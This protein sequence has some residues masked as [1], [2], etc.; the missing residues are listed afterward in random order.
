MEWAWFHRRKWWARQSAV[1]VGGNVLCQGLF[2]SVIS[3]FIAIVFSVVNFYEKLSLSAKSEASRRLPVA[4]RK[5]PISA[6]IDHH[7]I[8]HHQNQLHNMDYGLVKPCPLCW[9][10]CKESLLWWA[11]WW[12]WQTGHSYSMTLRARGGRFHNLKIDSCSWQRFW[13]LLQ[14]DDHHGKHL[15]YN[16]VMKITSSATADLN[17]YTN[18]KK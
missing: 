11:R 14:M 5:K 6:W 17:S 7:R 2:Q 4:P 10:M 8:G 15:S 12:T 9:V 16:M 3:F 18:G 13:S 1:W